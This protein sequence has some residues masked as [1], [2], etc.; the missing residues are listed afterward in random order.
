MILV[1]ILWVNVLSFSFQK[2]LIY[3]PAKRISGKMALN[4]PYFDDL[5]K[6]TLPANLIKK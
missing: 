4:H 6:S 1:P 3:D 5:D 2:M